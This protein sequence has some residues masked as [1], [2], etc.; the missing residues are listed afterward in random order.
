MLVT[1]VA[2][3]EF[4]DLDLWLAWD[5]LRRV[6]VPNWQVEIVADRPRVRS[7]TGVLT[8]AGSGLARTRE[9]SAVYFCGGPGALKKCRER[10]FVQALHIDPQR[11]LLAAVNAGVLLPGALGHLRGKRVTTVPDRLIQQQL[12]DQGAT[13][14][15]L[16]FIEQG[17]LAT[18]AQSLAATHLVE[19][20]IERLVGRAT[21]NRVIDAVAP[22]E[23]AAQL[24]L[25][26]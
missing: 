6:A 26:P 5:L 21:A 20:L 3:D 15:G 10:A 8:D 11:Q 2:F 25:R 13:V 22:L 1:L 23:V 17:R 4:T 12:R 19:W 9:A 14:E 7:A 18:A 24:A 16:S